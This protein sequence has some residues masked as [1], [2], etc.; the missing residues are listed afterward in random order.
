M[1]GEREKAN[2]GAPARLARGHSRRRA[3]QARNT[4][5]PSRFLTISQQNTAVEKQQSLSGDRGN[6]CRDEAWLGVVWLLRGRM[7]RLHS[8]DA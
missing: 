1:V 8:L 3:F 2:E 5:Q 6:S 4:P 7:P